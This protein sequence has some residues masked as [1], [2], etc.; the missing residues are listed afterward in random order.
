LTLILT[1]PLIALLIGTTP[2]EI[3]TP[4]DFPQGYGFTRGVGYAFLHSSSL[5]FCCCSHPCRPCFLSVFATLSSSL[6]SSPPPGPRLY[7][8][9]P[10]VARQHDRRTQ[11]VRGSTAPTP[12]LYQRRITTL[13][14]LVTTPWQ[15]F[16]PRLRKSEGRFPRTSV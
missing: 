9:A 5:L 15:P 1:R 10:Q 2:S 12:I 6:L 8:Y 11:N 3:Q 7:V 4:V 14:L 13:S 16:V